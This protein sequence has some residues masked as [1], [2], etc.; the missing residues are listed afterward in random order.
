M[1]DL[2]RIAADE[3]EARLWA[4]DHGFLQWTEG[5]GG[6]SAIA[7]ELKVRCYTSA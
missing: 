5:G 6:A 4:D 2:A 7:A 1:L 3:G